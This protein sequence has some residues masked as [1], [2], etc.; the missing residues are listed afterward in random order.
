MFYP[1][2]SL[3][4][5]LD[6]KGRVRIL[7]ITKGSLQI[8]PIWDTTWQCWAHHV[9]R[10]IYTWYLQSFKILT[11]ILNLTTFFFNSDHTPQIIN[12]R[13]L[14]DTGGVWKIKMRIQI[15]V[16][17]GPKNRGR[18]LPVIKVVLEGYHRYFFGVKV[19]TVKL[20]ERS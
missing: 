4:R 7:K 5:E 1:F 13:H 18:R 16:H 20:R 8:L 12:G 17:I 9:D 10:I 11:I 15:L 19:K 3:S 6:G 2:A 14:T